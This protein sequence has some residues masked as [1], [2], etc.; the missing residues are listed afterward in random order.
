MEQTR[1]VS[2]MNVE[3]ENSRASSCP[4]CGSRHLMRD[5]HMFTAGQ[6]ERIGV[7]A[8]PGAFLR[9]A[10][11]VGYVRAS[12]CGNCGY[13]EFHT[14]EHEKMWEAWREENT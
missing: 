13:T 9:M 11:G 10:R 6:G 1:K 5:L 2:E 8:V 7:V 12:V 3:D 14:L 4:K